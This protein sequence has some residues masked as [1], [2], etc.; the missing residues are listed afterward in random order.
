V[1]TSAKRGLLIVGHGTR[2]KVGLD[3]FGALVERIRFRTDCPVEPGFLELAQPTIAEGLARLIDRGAERIT[4]APLLLF[5]AGHAK[6]DIPAAVAEFVARY[7]NLA[8]QQTPPLELHESVLELSARR[9]NEAIAM[10]PKMESAETLL[11]MVGRGSRD[12]DATTEM[13]RFA[14]LRAGRTP[15]GEVRVC[16][17]AMQSPA[18][19]DVLS[20]AAARDFPRIVVQPHLLFHGVLYDEIKSAVEVRRRQSQK[21]WILTSV[22]GPEP[23]LADGVLDLVESSTAMSFR[24]QT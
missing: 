10:Q 24:W 4:I 22:L 9:F 14:R 15:V 11:V 2:D 23:E 1:A 12:L 16:F 5:A 18:L 6:R 13:H 21:E 8:I 17:L 20:D 3:E 19:S 7:P